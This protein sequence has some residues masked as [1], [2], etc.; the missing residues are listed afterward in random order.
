[1][2]SIVTGV[3]SGPH[4]IGGT[5][6]TFGTDS[7]T[8]STKAKAEDDHGRVVITFKS[9]K[10]VDESGAEVGV[11]DT[12]KVPSFGADIHVSEAM[13]DT[14]DNVS[15]TYF[16]AEMDAS[17]GEMNIT[18]S[19]YTQNGTV[20]EHAGNGTATVRVGMVEVQMIV[21][22][23][24]FCGCESSGAYLDLLTN[25]KGNETIKKESDGYTYNLGNGAIATV[26]NMVCTVV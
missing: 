6:I 2:I 4:E 23:W 5:H 14:Y 22:A 25:F 13:T 24:T 10:E 21:G 9:I 18:V 15:R 7:L 17:V 20:S 8:I 11:N 16:N 19:V 1:M 26:K 3:G 12:H